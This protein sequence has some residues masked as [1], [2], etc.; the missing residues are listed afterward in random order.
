MQMDRDAIIN[1]ERYIV[2]QFMIAISKPDAQEINGITWFVP[3]GL[4]LGKSVV[5]T[6]VFVLKRK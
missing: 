2:R 1:R 3:Q 4:G 6:P 5:K